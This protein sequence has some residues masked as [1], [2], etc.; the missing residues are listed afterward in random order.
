MAKHRDSIDAVCEQWAATRRELLGLTNPRF[1]SQYLGAVRCT[2]A[3]RRDLHHG[4]SSGRIEQHF[5][6]VYTGLA[7]VVNQAF[8]R[9]H[10]ALADVFDLHYGCTGPTHTKWQ[11]L[12]IGRRS[13]WERVG[14]A[15]ERVEGWLECTDEQ[16]QMC[17]LVS[18]GAW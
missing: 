6:E 9:M 14:R 15:K 16:A 3:E 4:S 8:K 11:A 1:A 5:P 13:Y 7:F 17:T 12:G 2:L 18:A 10:P